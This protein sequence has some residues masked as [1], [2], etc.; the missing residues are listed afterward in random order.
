MR[1]TACLPHCG[2]H[3][4][5]FLWFY[6]GSEQAG[7]SLGLSWQPAGITE[8][9]LPWWW[10]LSQQRSPFPWGLGSPPAYPNW[11]GQQN[12]LVPCLLRHASE[13]QSSGGWLGP[14]LPRDRTAP[15]LSFL[16]P[17]T[18]AIKSGQLQWMSWHEHQVGGSG[19]EVLVV[20]NSQ[21]YEESKNRLLEKSCCVI[22][23][24]IVSKFTPQPKWL[25]GHWP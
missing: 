24:E 8:E 18:V 17:S 3:T 2:E 14:R 11:G 13:L 9:H 12:Y 1:Q 10:S 22:Q 25:H 6:P 21:C 4:Q 5:I 7:H 15:K 16:F 20:I 23:K 19:M